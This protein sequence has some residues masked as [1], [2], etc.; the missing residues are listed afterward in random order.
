MRVS[1]GGEDD[2]FDLEYMEI[3]AHVLLPG[4]FV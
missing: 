3:E 2:E 4:E 1:E